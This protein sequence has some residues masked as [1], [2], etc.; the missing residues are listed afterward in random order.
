MNRSV[1]SIRHI[2][3]LNFCSAELV[4]LAQ[5][6]DEEVECS[7]STKPGSSGA[8]E[9]LA[10]EEE[11]KCIYIP[12]IP[13]NFKF[14]QFIVEFNKGKLKEQMVQAIFGDI[15]LVTDG[16]EKIYIIDSN[17]A[18]NGGV[19]FGVNFADLLDRVTYIIAN[20]GREVQ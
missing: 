11:N 10:I 19:V 12:F 16:S 8:K 13:S 9:E 20:S 6:F 18:H 15:S 14:F 4:P 2:I 1:R 17:P 5:C 3:G 7:F